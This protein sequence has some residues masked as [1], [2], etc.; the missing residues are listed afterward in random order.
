[1]TDEELEQAL[2]KLSESIEELSDPEKPLSKE[3]RKH[4][5]ILLLKKET[6]QKLKQAREKNDKHQEFQHAA[7][8][9]L[10]T[11][12]GEKH[13]FLLHLARIKLRWAMF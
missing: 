2:Q 12:W 6:L 8:Y 5:Y 3:E 7:M 10:L 13:P 1:M 11:S 9:G 4:Q